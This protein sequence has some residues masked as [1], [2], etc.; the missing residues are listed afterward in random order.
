MS[1]FS[2]KGWLA[3]YEGLGC[4]IVIQGPHMIAGTILDGDP[5]R[6]RIRRALVDE[7]TGHP[8]R[9]AAVRGALLGRP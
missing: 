2:A 6:H 5:G 8:D 1:G 4:H 9:I 3:A 7:L